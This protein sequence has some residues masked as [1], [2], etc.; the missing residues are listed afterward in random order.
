MKVQ[1][2]DSKDSILSYDL[3]VKVFANSISY[4]YRVYLLY[5]YHFDLIDENVYLTVEFYPL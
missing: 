5:D 1:E 3:L 2:D 4:Q